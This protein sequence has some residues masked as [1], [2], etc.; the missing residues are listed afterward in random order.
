MVGRWQKRNNRPR[1]RDSPPCQAAARIRHPTCARRPYAV[2]LSGSEGSHPVTLSG[3]KG[4]CIL[5]LFFSV[6][7]HLCICSA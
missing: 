7:K 5:C 2:T 3:A 4:L 1:V 6:T